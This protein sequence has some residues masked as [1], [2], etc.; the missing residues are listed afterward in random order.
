MVTEWRTLGTL[1]QVLITT[2]WNCKKNL[3]PKNKVS[4][5]PGQG[6]VIQ[7][8]CNNAKCLHFVSSC[9]IPP[10]KKK[11]TSLRYFTCKE[12]NINATALQVLQQ[13]KTPAVFSDAPFSASENAARLPLQRMSKKAGVPMGG[14]CRCNSWAELGGSRLHRKMRCAF[15]VLQVLHHTGTE[16]LSFK[17]ALEWIYA[18][19]QFKHLC[20]YHESLKTSFATPKA[21][22]FSKLSRAP[23][24]HT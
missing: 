13:R 7:T 22:L 17:N 18:H 11:P 21:K 3:I 16:L 10:F 1:W 2:I 15:W 4:S 23:Q 12:Q 8:N 5:L 9:F 24:L 20:C 14:T 6:Q 19:N